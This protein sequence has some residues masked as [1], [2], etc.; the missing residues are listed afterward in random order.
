MH[1]QMYFFSSS[2]GFSL[3]YF[4]GFTVKG[5]GLQGGRMLHLSWVSRPMKRWSMQCMFCFCIYEVLQMMKN[6]WLPYLCCTLIYWYT[7]LTIHFVVFG[8]LLDFEFDIC[9]FSSCPFLS[10]I[11]KICL[12]EYDEILW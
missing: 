3:M 5:L 8:I 6:L 11:C 2:N 1:L 10:C 12:G 7:F 9:N 4:E